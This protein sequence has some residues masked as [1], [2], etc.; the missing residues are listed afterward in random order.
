MSSIAIYMEGGGKGRDTKT[1]LRQGMDGFLNP[2]K[3]AI[4]SKSWR[5]KL[6]PCGSRDEAFRNF[7]HAVLNDDN[8]III[9]LV[10]AEDPVKTSVREH[11]KSRDRW[12]LDFTTDDDVHLMIQTMETWIVADIAA[13]AD[14]YGQ[15]FQQSALPSTSALEAIS[16][17]EI[18]RA[19]KLATKATLKREYHK[20]RHASDLLKRIDSS[21]VR[22][23]CQSCE[24]LFNTVL[25]AIE[26][27]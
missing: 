24:R 12:E 5:W 3:E 21:K 4:R 8:R 25:Q 14:Y 19:L 26:A 9:L 11:L 18:T 23:R 2:I 27:V 15:N 16:K 13:L 20:I 7:K 22:Q 6:V 10:D 1:A 17:R